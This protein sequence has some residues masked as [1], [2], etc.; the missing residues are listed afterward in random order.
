[1]PRNIADQIAVS[2]T[3]LIIAEGMAQGLRLTERGL[4]ERFKVSRSPIREALR[5]LAT[6]GVV[7]ALPDGGFSVAQSGVDLEAASDAALRTDDD[8]DGP[9]LQIAEDHLNGI[10]PERVTESELL[11]RYPISAATLRALLGRMTQE[12]WIERLPGN[13][14]RFLPVLTSAETYNQGYRFRLLIESAALLEPTFK[15]D[16]PALLRC[17]DEQLKLLANLDNVSPVAVFD[18]NTHLH[19]ALADMSGNTFIIDALHRLNCLRRL[20]EYRKVTS[21]ENRRRRI[22]EHLSLIDLVLS[23]QREAAADFMRLHLRDAAREKAA[24]AA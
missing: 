12:G 16:E 4:A 10:L 19:E 23:G 1:M 13:G 20:M 17:R 22:M 5:K 7:Q 2:I 11:R 8:A 21:A 18:A 24:S 14:W 6:R 15:L 3:Q 9:Y